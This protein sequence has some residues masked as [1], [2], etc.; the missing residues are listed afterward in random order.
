[1]CVLGIQQLQLI[2]LK[3]ALIVAVEFHIN[4]EFVK[5]LE[6]PEDQENEGIHLHGHLSKQEIN[7]SFYIHLLDSC[8]MICKLWRDEEVYADGNKMTGA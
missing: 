3:V 4:V 7:C 5:L 1:M 8:F 2:L 6:P